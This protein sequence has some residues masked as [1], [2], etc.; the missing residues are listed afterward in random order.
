MRGRVAPEAYGGVAP[1]ALHA[2]TN[3]VYVHRDGKRILQRA[4]ATAM[5]DYV[6]VIAERYRRQGK[7]RNDRQRQALFSNLAKAE[8]FYD[9]LLR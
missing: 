9:R 7:F 5:A 1:W 3:P 4:D 6:R 8:A 2:H